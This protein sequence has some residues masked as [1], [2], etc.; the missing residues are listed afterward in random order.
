[1]HS[2]GTYAASPDK[3]ETRMDNLW[4]EF[5]QARA[6]CNSSQYYAIYVIV[7]DLLM[8]SEPLEKTRSERLEKIMLASDFSDLRGAPEA[9][10]RLQERV[11]QLEDIKT[12]FQIHGKHLDKKGW[13]DRLVLE[14]DL[15]ACEDELFFMMKAITTSQRKFDSSASSALLKWS[16]SVKEIV[17]QLIR[18]N[19]EPLVELQLKDVEYDR[20]D[21]ADGSHINLIQV[22]KILGLNLLP[23]A[24]YPA[25]IALLSSF[26]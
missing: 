10:L 25:M 12:H 6:L 26:L 3:T 16:I 14:R 19:N 13:K 15:A 1:M 4:V 9:V 22:G 20:T 2:E 18:D 11:R 8:Y 23:D 24:I 21:N 5:P 17:W 7:L